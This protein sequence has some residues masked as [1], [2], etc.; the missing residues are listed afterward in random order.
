MA[1][2]DRA[3][4]LRLAPPRTLARKKRKPAFPPA[5]TRDPARHARLLQQGA[6]LT[7]QHLQEAARQFPQ[8]ATDVPYVRIQVAG[9]TV[10]TDDEIKAL[11]LI[12]VY[13]REDAVL[14]A[15]ATDRELKTLESQLDSYA[16][17]RKKLAALSKIE[18]IKPWSREDR[19]SVR[20]KATA[21]EADHEYI[22]DVLLLPV[23]GRSVNPQ[24][25]SAIERFVAGQGGRVVDRA[26]E[27]SFTAARLRLGGQALENLLEYRDD[28]ALVD[29]P[30]AAHVL[31]PQILS[32]DIA[33]ISEL[34]APPPTAPAVCVV[35]SGILEGHPLLEPAILADRS[36][37]FPESLGKPIPELPVGKAGHGTQV[38]GVALY[39]DVGARAV[40]K[41]FTPELWL[42]NA[43]FLDDQ[44]ELHPDRMPFLREVVQHVQDRCR[45]FNLSFGL[46]PCDGF[47]SV[48]AAE[49]DAL[50]REFGVLFVVA[51][52]NAN[53]SAF[54]D[55]EPPRKPYPDFLLDPACRVLAPAEALNGLTVGGLTPAQEILP[56]NPD[57][58]LVAPKRAPSPFSRAGALKNVVKPEL[59]DVAGNVAYDRTLKR[60]VTN[61]P[62]L[63]VATT[64]PRLAEGQLLGFAHGTSVA[65]PKVAYLAARILDR[66]PEATPN[67]LRA[68]LIQSARCPEGVADWNKTE[69]L[70]LCG[71]GVP[72]LD[73]A[74][75]CRSE[76][77]TLYYE[78]EIEVDEVKL[79]EI[80]V[81]IEFARAAGRKSISVTVAYDPPVSVVH[82]DRPAGINLAWGLARGDV[83]ERTLEAAI[84][85]EAEEEIETPPPAVREEA[86]TRRKS[87]FMPGELPKRLQQRGTVQ[88]NVFTWKRGEH[89]DTYRLAV[90]AKATRPA[91]ARDRQRFAVVVTLESEDA[92]VNVFNTVRVR[93]A[94]ARVRVRVKGE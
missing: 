44:N 22:V 54:F 33:G 41:S 39:G 72:D 81:P 67:L 27:P 79:F 60:W 8:L 90:M 9:G 50:V 29:L 66:Y 63:G 21:I 93:L 2:D 34:P 49:I 6:E 36:R 4:L 59:V 13:R 84:A 94:A 73:R 58:E 46:E 52:G 89:G 32:F 43:R 78:G 23:E 57:R 61:V 56:K 30:P 80:P 42:V 85:A 83:P 31:V 48:H 53:V 18:T 25:L 71:F 62:G 64:S 7:R 82:R 75:F 38:A 12:P 40:A 86:G 92:K 10:L 1:D 74:L 14:A 20:L 68:L 70:K 26:L 24:A 51:A 69:A 17:Q 47:V 16:R 28:I 45:V 88:K 11:G 55:G 19:T 15:Y 76:R 87:P 65:A 5:P 35:D 91:H 37:A 3:A 77:A